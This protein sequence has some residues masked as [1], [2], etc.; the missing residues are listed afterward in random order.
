LPWPVE[1]HISPRQRRLRCAQAT[2]NLALVPAAREPASDIAPLLPHCHRS[3]ARRGAPFN[4]DRCGLFVATV[5]SVRRTQRAPASL[6]DVSSQCRIAVE[7]RSTRERDAPHA[8]LMRMDARQAARTGL[9]AVLV[10]PELYRWSS[11]CSPLSPRVPDWS[12]TSLVRSDKVARVA[13][14]A[15]RVSLRP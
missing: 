9:R 1:T 11:W 6:R 4:A 7:R 3:T 10:G 13:T 2:P 8:P 14:C 5:R 12:G 15:A